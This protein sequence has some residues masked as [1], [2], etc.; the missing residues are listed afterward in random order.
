MTV[1]HVSDKL[2][3]MMLPFGIP[4]LNR[5]LSTFLNRY[6]FLVAVLVPRTGKSIALP[7]F[8]L[9]DSFKSLY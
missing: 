1:L 4:S 7:H 3:P 2:S 9:C 5:I 8:E 6:R